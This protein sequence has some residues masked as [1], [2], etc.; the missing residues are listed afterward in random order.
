MYKMLWDLTEL[1]ALLWLLYCLS[2]ALYRKW[3]EVNETFDPCEK[4]QSPPSDKPKPRYFDDDPE[5][6]IW[7]IGDR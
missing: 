6:F 2:R 5:D 1:V 3:K 4:R 7:R